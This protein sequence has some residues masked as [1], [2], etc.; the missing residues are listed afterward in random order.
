VLLGTVVVAAL[1]AGCGGGG[2]TDDHT[3]ALDGQEVV[4]ELSVVAKACDAPSYFAAR[5]ALDRLDQIAEEDPHTEIHAPRGVQGELGRLER[6][7]R[8]PLTAR[9]IG[10]TISDGASDAGTI[11]DVLE[12]VKRTYGICLEGNA[13]DDLETTLARISVQQS[14]D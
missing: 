14:R 12:A 2:S 13:L 11:K 9:P 6:G 4:D 10:R 7:L 5:E 1:I 8:P 3:Q